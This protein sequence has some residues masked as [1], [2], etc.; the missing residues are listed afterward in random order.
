MWYTAKAMSRR[1]F[2]ILSAYTKKEERRGVKM[3]E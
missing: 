1:K 2:I 3:V